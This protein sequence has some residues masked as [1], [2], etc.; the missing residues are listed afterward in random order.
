MSSSGTTNKPLK[1]F[2]PW[3]VIVVGIALASP[4]VTADFTADDHLHRVI[5]RDETGIRGLK[6]RP[7]DLFVFADGDPETNIALRDQGLYPWWVDTDMKLAFWRPISSA[8]HAAD[9]ALWP[10]NAAAQLAHNLVWLALSLVVVWRFYRRFT[11]GGATWIA[12]LA[13]ALYAFDDARGPVVGWIANR[14][15]LVALVMS[16]PALLAHDRWRRDGWQ[17][18]RWVAPLLF[19]LSLG[20]GES[21]VAILAYIA[22][23]ALWL[24]RAAWKDRALALAPY[25]A[26]LVVWRVIYVKLGYGVHGSGIYLDPGSDPV[27]FVGELVMR[28]PHLLLGQLG[29]PWSDGASLYDV[30]GLVGIM[31]GFALVSLGL[32]SAASSRLLKTEPSTRF[33]ATGMFLAAVPVASTFPADRLLT[34]VGLGGMGLVAQ[35]IAAALRNRA[36]LGDGKLRRAFGVVVAIGMILTH[37]VI[38][39]PMLVLRSRSMVAV[40]RIIDRADA[41]IPSDPTKTVV[42]AAA[43]SDALA[44]Y[45]PLQRRSRDLPAPAH[46][47]WLADATAAVTFER[48]DAHTLRVTP[49][50]GL[51]RY[52]LDRMMRDPRTKPFSAGDEV[53]LPG[54]T[55]TVERVTSDRRPA[56]VIARFDVVLEDPSL[57]WLRWD[58][59]T[60]VPWTPP[61]VGH[62]ETLPIADLGKLLEND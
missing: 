1:A 61:S 16:L 24:D 37:L 35:L 20:A 40:G 8:T 25:A 22:A 58:T 51:L 60:Y 54:A 9:H 6:S 42:I 55:I 10:D 17:P 3:L 49:D 30:A 44:G 43:A 38:A 59:K 11:P 33:F 27:G 13:L 12:V 57:Q 29:L 28:V 31:M 50:G 46:I 23:H 48:L 52:G 62:S 41:S 34:F 53:R 7:L 21:S 26:I 36:Q 45:V 19:A 32:I 18:G 56:S 4:A 15:A 14:N 5:Q 47:W 39:P 2:W